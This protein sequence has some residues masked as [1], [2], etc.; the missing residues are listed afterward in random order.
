MC[1]QASSWAMAGWQHVIQF[2]NWYLCSLSCME[3]AP[4]AGGWIVRR[5]LLGE[6]QRFQSYSKREAELGLG[7][8]SFFVVLGSVCCPGSFPL[9]VLFGLPGKVCS[10]LGTSA[11][12]FK[13][14]NIW[15]FPVSSGAHVGGFGSGQLVPLQQT[16][17]NQ[18]SEELKDESGLT[19]LSSRVFD[20]K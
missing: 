19:G 6:G 3:S 11:P 20:E 1:A 10:P 4:L 14:R 15:G 7:Y 18:L 13:H 2:M 5:I 17:P 12:S 8:V 9:W 16:P